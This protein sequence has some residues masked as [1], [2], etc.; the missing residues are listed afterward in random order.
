MLTSKRMSDE[1]GGQV[2]YVPLKRDGR[3]VGL[4]EVQINE[5]DSSENSSLLRGIGIPDAGD[6]LERAG[7]V[8]A[9]ACVTVMGKI[10]DVV[11]E[12]L[13]DSLELHFGVNF[14]GEAGIPVLTK[15]SV[16]TTL[17]VTAKWTK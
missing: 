4:L 12:S 16:E 13:P 11:G 1:R 2:R 5:Q 6:S 10:V 15:A 17:E 14:S 9:E 7:V 3:V 8:I